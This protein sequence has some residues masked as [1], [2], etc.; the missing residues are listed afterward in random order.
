MA[1]HQEL[2]R[3]NH[4][5]EVLENAG[6]IKAASILHKKFIK[7][8]QAAPQT[9]PQSYVANSGV[10]VT[11][12]ENTNNQ[13]PPAQTQPPAQNT[14]QPTLPPNYDPYQNYYQDPRTGRTVIVDPGTGQ[15]FQNQQGLPTEMGKGLPVTPPGTYQNP[16]GGT[17][18]VPN[19]GMNINPTPAPIKPPQPPSFPPP[20]NENNQIPFLQDRYGFYFQKINDGYGLPQEQQQAYF[21]RIKKQLFDQ[22]QQ[23]LIDQKTYNDLMRLFSGK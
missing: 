17:Y 23:G 1:T 20:G 16:G 9:G 12:P 18:T 3:L 19:P 6:L 7:E 8:A 15:P 10:L 4:D 2:L 13:T 14:V 11:K 22:L 21:D 5:I